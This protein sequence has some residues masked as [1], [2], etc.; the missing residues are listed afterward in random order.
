M[1]KSSLQAKFV[2]CFPELRF[3]KQDYLEHEIREDAVEFYSQ[4]CETRVAG[5][6]FGGGIKPIRP[7]EICFANFKPIESEMSIDRWVI[8]EL[9]K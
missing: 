7:L 6:W 1:Y 3:P 5:P 4:K 9:K 8:T 2:V